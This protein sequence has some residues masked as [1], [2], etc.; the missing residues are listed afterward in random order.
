LAED[1]TGKAYKGARDHAVALLA[2]HTLTVAQRGGASGAVSQMSEGSLSVGFGSVDP[3]G[4]D[5]FHTTAYGAE[6]V[7]LRRSYIM[8]ARTVI[9]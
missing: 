1:Q 2:A 3:M 9:V 8:T 6:L 7:R 5:Q 4:T